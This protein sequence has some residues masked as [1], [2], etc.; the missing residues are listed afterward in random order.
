VRVRAVDVLVAAH[1]SPLLAAGFMQNDWVDM[2]T[3]TR[4]KHPADDAKEVCK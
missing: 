1:T 4:M 2:R 3:A